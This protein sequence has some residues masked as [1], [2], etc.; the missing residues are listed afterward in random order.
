MP[1]EEAEMTRRY[2]LIAGIAGAAL[3]AWWWRSRH[4]GGDFVTPSQLKG[5]VVFRNSPIASSEGI[6]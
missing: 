6:L 2:G 5:E 3:A 1:T 4:S